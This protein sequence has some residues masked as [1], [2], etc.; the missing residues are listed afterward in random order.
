MMRLSVPK[1][2]ASLAL[3]ILGLGLATAL[4]AAAGTV[5]Y[6]LS[7]FGNGSLNGVGFSNTA[8]TITMV[9]DPSTATDN[10]TFTQIN[11]LQT[12]DVNLTGVGDAVISSATRIGVIDTGTN[13][14]FGLVSADLF[15]FG[16][17]NGFK[18]NLPYGPATLPV[19]DAYA[20][21]QFVNISTSLGPLTLSSLSG[22]SFQFMAGGGV[23]SVPEPASLALFGVGLA[24]LACVIRQR[25][26]A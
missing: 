2:V 10:G 12:T 24:G 16:Q 15:D 25:K 11:P 8:F 3:G 19:S 17:L 1:A 6:T 18:L 7:G 14:F 22:T 23:S 4:P 26:A 20:L 9:G 13:A 5:D 21:S